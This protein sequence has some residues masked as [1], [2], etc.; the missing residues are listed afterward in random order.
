MSRK[1]DP[2]LLRAQAAALFRI[3]LQARA[4]ALAE[5]RARHEA[6]LE[7]AARLRA[8]RLAAQGKR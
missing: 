6:E 3:A 8:E 4:D 7:K 1:P 5:H 2:V